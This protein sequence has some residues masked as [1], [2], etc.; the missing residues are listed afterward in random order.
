MMVVVSYPA[1]ASRDR[2]GKQDDSGKETIRDPLVLVVGTM[3][4]CNS[5][6]KVLLLFDA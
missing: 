3:D 6:D 4:E 2:A 1:V 5:E